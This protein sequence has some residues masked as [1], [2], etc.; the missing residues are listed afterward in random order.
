MSPHHTTPPVADP[1]K[2]SLLLNRQA[3]EL[4]TELQADRLNLRRIVKGVAGIR[5]GC[6][7]KTNDPL[8]WCIHDDARTALKFA[9]WSERTSE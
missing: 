7:G 9:E 6:C 1:L 2:V 5:D 8:A 3:D 4:I